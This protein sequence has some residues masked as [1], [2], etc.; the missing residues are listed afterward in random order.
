MLNILHNQNG[1]FVAQSRANFSHNLQN[2]PYGGFNLG[3]HTGDEPMGVLQNRSQL[4]SLI[5]QATNN[6]IK[7]L[8]WLTQI[9]SNLITTPRSPT[10]TP[11]NADVWISDEIGK[12][13]VIVTADCVPI[14]LVSDGNAQNGAIACIHA[15]WQGLANGAIEKTVQALPKDTYC[16]YVGSCIGGQNY[17]IDKTLG[18]RIVNDC[19]EL[20]KVSK[21]KLYNAILRPNDKADK[22]Y[23]DVLALTLL[24]LAK[25]D[26]VPFN[27]NVLC[28]YDGTKKG[29][30][31]SHRFAT[32]QNWQ[33]TGRMAMIVAKLR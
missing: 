24:Q 21:D 22:C 3:L 17:E 32:H 9:H 23:L 10:L 12:G 33:N 28:S 14:V 30:Q 1:I 26:I 16:A 6:Q 15:G 31:Y 4:L 2:A 25:H 19:L 18:E 20:V 7:S 13:L 11:T 29:E 27:T 5:N 8:H